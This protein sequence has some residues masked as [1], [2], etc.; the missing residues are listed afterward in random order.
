MKE[1]DRKYQKTLYQPLKGDACVNDKDED[2]CGAEDKNC[3]IVVD[4]EQARLQVPNYNIRA[5]DKYSSMR[6]G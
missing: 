4:L 2:W 5:T 3:E 1:T 6:I